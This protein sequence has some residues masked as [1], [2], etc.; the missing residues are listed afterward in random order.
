[1]FGISEKV[2]VMHQGRIIFE[3]TPKQVKANDEV[4]RIYLGKVK[5]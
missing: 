3:G 2:K 5:K 1:V 4:Q